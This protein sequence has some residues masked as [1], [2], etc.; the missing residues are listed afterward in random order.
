MLLGFNMEA[1]FNVNAPGFNGEAG[2]T[3]E[4]PGFNQGSGDLESP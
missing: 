2:F 1:G 4:A 3:V